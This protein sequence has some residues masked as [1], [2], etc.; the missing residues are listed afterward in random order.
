M[1]FLIFILISLF[2]S[3][4]EWQ[5]IK[6]SFNKK[7]FGIFF[8]FYSFYTAYLLRTIENNDY[9]IFIVITLIC[10]STDIGGYIFGKLIKGPKLTRISPNKTY[11]GMFGSYILCFLLFVIILNYGY[12]LKIYA[13]NFLIFLIII[14][15]VSQ[16]G[17]IIM[18]YFKRLSNIKDT[19][20]IIPGHG[21]ILDRIDGMIFAYPTAYLI[22]SLDYFQKII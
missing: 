9:F 15:S 20:T 12:I 7:L 21:G 1:F 13:W 16:L 5:K 17:D 18:S 8:L 3:I 6:I 10:I 22:L 4:Y 19:G 14:S 11:S 2:I